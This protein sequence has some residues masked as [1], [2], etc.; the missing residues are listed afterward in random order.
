MEKTKSCPILKRKCLKDDCAWYD[1][2]ECSVIAAAGSG[3][4][5]TINDI[6]DELEEVKKLLE[7]KMSN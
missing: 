3:D 6:L 2:T 7:T 4:S 1:E 5:V